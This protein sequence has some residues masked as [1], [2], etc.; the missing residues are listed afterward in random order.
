MSIWRRILTALRGIVR[1]DAVDRELD[2]EMRDFMEKATEEHRRRGLDDE[3]AARAARVGFGSRAAV[4]EEVR[5][6]F[7]EWSV[8]TFL[9]DLRYGARALART[10]GFAAV[11]ILTLAPGFGATTAVLSV[12][13][14]V[15]FRP[16]PVT[17]PQELVLFSWN[18]PPHGMPPISIAGMNIDAVTG[19]SSSTAFSWQAFQRF[20]NASRTLKDVLAF[21]FASG[22]PSA[23]GLDDAPGGQLVTGNYFEVLGTRPHLGRLLSRDDDREGAPLVAVV[24]YRYWQRELGGD[25]NVLG[26]SLRLFQGVATIVGVTPAG[27]NGTGQVGDAPDF[28]LPLRPGAPAA[29]NKFAERMMNIAWVWPLRILGRLAPGATFEDARQ[30][31]EPAFQSAVKE[32][33][34]TNPRRLTQ[35]APTGTPRLTASSGSQGLSSR[36]E[37]LTHAIVVLGAIVGV[38]LIIV[39]ANLASLLFARGE[40]RRTEM[41]V[42]RAIG[43]GRGRLVRQLLTE[44]VFMTACGAL[45]GIVLARWT[46]DL[47]LAWLNRTDPSFVIEPSL[48]PRV[49]ALSGGIAVVVAMVVG[50]IPAWRATRVDPNESLKQGTQALAGGRDLIGRALLVAQV[51]LALVLVVAAGLFVR[52]LRNLETLDVGFNQTNLLLFNVARTT[53][54]PAKGPAAVE[55]ALLF[56]RLVERL[57]AVPGVHAAGFSQY[58]LLGGGLAMPYLSVPDQPRAAG[59]DRTV[60]AQAISP[61]FIRTME[62]SIVE[63]RDLTRADRNLAV[64]VVNETLARRFFPD[65]TAI[66]RRVALTKDANAPEVSADQLLEIVGV[67]R[68]AKYMTTREHTLPTLFHTRVDMDRQAFAVR[69]SADPLRLVPAIQEAMKGLPSPVAGFDFRTQED[70][71]ATTFAEERHFAMVSTVFGALALGLTAIGL[72]GLLSYRVARRTQE[73]GIRMALGAGGSRIARGVLADVLAIVC[74]G[75]ILGLVAASFTTRL[76]QNLL[77]GLTP[78][79]P[80]S[81]AVAVIVM[82]IVAAAAGYLPARRAARV[83]P[84][85]ALRAQ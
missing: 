27:F 23:P 9:R 75:V 67:V 73:I 18:A 5:A 69:A 53:P 85:V 65:G 6:G 54:A 71:S 49:L 46:K 64:A 70:Q 56:D 59:E 11:A 35:P 48:D 26:K 40:A 10:P 3:A 31:L 38:L 29:G 17:N 16:L 62:M 34:D 68:D 44:A 24:S 45:G 22:A 4:R 60:Y 79:D 8:L 84:L 74:A 14:V 47:M 61:G 36:R 42:R 33:W 77:F 12:A 80:M 81:I 15:L 78:L 28:F 7:W 76:V 2:D 63:G 55:A 43:A 57:E 37:S 1:S 83:D 13:D 50:L 30:E 21:S 52:T 82:T 72:Y 39:S 58:S 20:Q 25:A 19:G 51:A 66:G 32:A 41:A